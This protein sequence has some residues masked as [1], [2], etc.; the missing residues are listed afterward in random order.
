MRSHS[1]APAPKAAVWARGLA[2]LFAC[3]N[4]SNSVAGGALCASHLKRRVCWLPG[5]LHGSTSGG[6][7]ARQPAGSSRSCWLCRQQ[8]SAAASPVLPAGDFR[9][10]P[11]PLYGRRSPPRGRSPP[12]PLRGGPPPPGMLLPPPRSVPALLACSCRLDCL[13]CLGYNRRNLPGPLPCWASRVHP[14]HVLPPPPSPPLQGGG[15]G[16]GAQ[17]CARG[18][19][20][21]QE[22]DPAAGGRPKQHPHRAPRPA[23]G[24]RPARRAGGAAARPHA[25]QVGRRRAGGA[26]AAVGRAVSW[27]WHQEHAK[28]CGCSPCR[29][30]ALA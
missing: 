7:A 16:G 29:S 1:L 23:G 22:P 27:S 8:G 25:Q 26:P 21:F 6:Q 3:W 18:A 17:A 11:P 28:P 2:M 20:H 30:L 5:P 4:G 10:P 15:D 24:A 9:G 14:P 12:P 19:E 13:P